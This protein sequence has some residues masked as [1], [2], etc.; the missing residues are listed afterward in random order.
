MANKDKYNNRAK[1]LIAEDDKLIARTMEYNLKKQGYDIITVDDGDAVFDTVNEVEPDVI[2]IDWCLPGITGIKICAMLRSNIATA[3]IPIIMISASDEDL[4]KVSGLEH[5]ADDYITKPFSQIELLARVKA[6]LRRIRPAFV[7]RKIEYHD[8]QMDMD[9]CTVK[10]NSAVIKLS[11]IEYQ[12]LQIMM[13]Y[14]KK[15]FSRDS[16]IARVWGENNDVDV[17]TVDVHITRLRKQLLSHSKDGVDI[18]TTVRGSG[19]RMM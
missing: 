16:L 11:P 5:G 1:I 7:E 19:Y 13:E 6:I 8:I 14:P 9:A 4:D 2:L 18:I 12:I 10:R 15:V 17:R 3:N